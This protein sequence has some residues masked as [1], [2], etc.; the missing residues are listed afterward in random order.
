MFSI[1]IFSGI[2][3]KHKIVHGT[4]LCGSII[5]MMRKKLIEKTVCLI[6]IGVLVFTNLIWSEDM[7][8]EKNGKVTFY[9]AK[10]GD[11]NNP[12]TEAQPFATIQHARDA[13]RKLIKTDLNTDVVVLIRSGAYY[14]NESLTF[15]PEDS[16]TEEHS[17]TY[18]AY[19]GETV[20]VV[21]G[22]E[23][24]EWK[25]NKGEI[26]EASIPEGVTPKQVFEN[27]M[28]LNLAR[29]PDEGYLHLEKP[30]SGKEGTD[31]IYRE[32]DLQPDDWDVSDASVFIWPQYDW[33][34]TTAPID[35]IDPKNHII[36]LKRSVGQMTSGNRYYIQNV[37]SLLD[38]PGECQISL[39]DHKIYAWAHKENQTMVISTVDNVIRIQGSD[40][41][42]KNLHFEDLDL[43]ISNGD[44]VNI[45]GAENC[46]FRFCKIENGYSYGVSINGYAQHINIYGNLI[47][48]NG[49]HGVSLEGLAP[50]QADVNKYNV[51]E[52][53][54]IHHC[55]RLV[56]HGYGVNISQSGYNKIIHNHIHN[57]PRYGTTIKGVR[58]QVLREQ[59]KGVTWENRHDFLHSRHNLIAYND[60]HNVNEDSQDTGAMESWG[61]GRDNVY[62]HNLIHDVGNNELNLQ[63]GIY[64]D[65]ATDYFTVT[66]NIIWEVIGK[67]PTS[68]VYAKGIGN[69]L[70]NN[71]FIVSD[72][73]TAAVSS[74]FMADERADNHV[75]THNIY[76]FEGSSGAIYD[77]YN[78]SED[79]VTESDYN[80]FWKPKGDL[81]MNGQ[82]PAK[83]FDEWKKILRNKYDQHSIVADPMFVDPANRNYH[84]QPDSPALKLGFKD[85]DTS[86]IGLKDDF[87]KRFE[88]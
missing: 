45:I 15:G 58:Y 27:G 63:M 67:A 56:G 46:S 53:N 49:N 44:V 68:S 88:R 51:I 22:I 34:S 83:T 66:N 76:Y 24:K 64:L 23:I 48:F 75:Y 8:N 78:W 29:T 40:Q 38:K 6:I 16:G 39:K 12:G 13:V 35:S 70:D 7:S 62:D 10:D 2:I 4:N 80:I 59:V 55:G 72:K 65:D 11:D 26:Q 73:N 14:L 84:L 43:S 37:L 9:V 20:S 74:L 61:P 60:I 36:K 17:I 32:G 81:A 85:I 50:G 25:H 71:I 5:L 28:R 82:S 54:H 31:F 52:N 30:V 41:I 87:P 21:G 57:M 47:R 18:M 86:E 77:F 42:V 69:K 19:P 33:F 1:L 79:R 3:E